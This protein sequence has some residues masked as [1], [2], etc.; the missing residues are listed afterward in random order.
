MG[1]IYWLLSEMFAYIVRNL[2]SKLTYLVPRPLPPPVFDRLQYAVTEGKN[3]G[4]LLCYIY[5]CT[6]PGMVQYM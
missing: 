2:L 1:L 4:D 6:V 5:M 3:S